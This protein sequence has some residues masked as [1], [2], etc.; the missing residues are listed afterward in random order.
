[1]IP[2]ST[3]TALTGTARTAGMHNPPITPFAAASQG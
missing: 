2:A 1:M 3:A